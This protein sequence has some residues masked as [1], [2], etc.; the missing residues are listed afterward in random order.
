MNRRP[1]ISL[2]IAILVLLLLAACQPVT[3]PTPTPTL[4][5]V[6][7]AQLVEQIQEISD[8]TWTV[9]SFGGPEQLIPG[10]DDTYPSV[11]FTLGRFNGFTGCNYFA[12]VYNVDGNA[13]QFD[14]PAVTGGSCDDEE[15]FEQENTFLTIL[16]T[17]TRFEVE[18]ENIILYADDQQLMTLEPLEPVPFEGTTW[19]HRFYQGNQ[20]MWQPLVPGTSIS[21]VFEGDTISGSAGCNQYTGTFTRNENEISIGELATTRMMCAEPEGIMDQEDRYLAALET[22]VAIRE[23]ARTIELFDAEQPIMLFSAD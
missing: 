6:E 22:V 1:F 2:S 20:P 10:V 11:N 16:I 17:A 3:E 19:N 18:G 21:A 14:P 9:Q 15:L 23:S 12:G 4:D 8:T 7:A 13:V 5:A